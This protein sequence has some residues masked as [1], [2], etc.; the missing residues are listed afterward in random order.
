MTLQTTHADH[1]AHSPPVDGAPR[2]LLKAEAP[3]TG[4]VDGAWWPYTD[5]LTIELP[6]LLAVLAMRLGPIH[7]VAYRL[8]EWASA[9]NELEIAGRTVR[10][11]GHRYRSDHTIEVLGDRD[12]RLVVLIIPPYTDAHDAFVAMT[13]ASAVNNASG[14]TDLLMIGRREHRAHTQ[15][16][17]AVQ[18]WDS[19][20]EAQLLG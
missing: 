16:A 17:A 14:V 4:Y 18:R 20:R 13:S 10:L 19:E 6:G 9:P 7:H 12:R 5:E 8:G 11:A 1:R 2:V 15:R 3:K